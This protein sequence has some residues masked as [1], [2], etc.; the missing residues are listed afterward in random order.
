MI[1]RAITVAASTPAIALAGV[2]WLRVAQREHYLVDAVSRFALRWWTRVPLNAA[3]LVLAVAGLLLSSRWPAFAF[4]PIAVVA[5]GP[6]GL[7]LRGRTAPLAWT[8][9]LRTLALVWAVLEVAAVVGGTLAGEGPVAAA[10]GVLAVPALVDLACWVTSPFERRLARTHVARASARLRRVAPRVVAI[11]GSY[12]KTSTKGYVAHLLGGSRAVVASPA[13]FNNR[14]G[15][16]RAVNEHLAEGTEVFVAEMGTYGRGEIA[17]LCS[18]VRP[19]VAVITAVGPVHLERFGSEDNVVRAK[20]EILD[21][22]G[23][24]VLVV[25]DD[26][27]AAL[28]D[29]AEQAGTRVWRVS[30]C[31]VDTDV[32]V[33]DEEGGFTVRVHGADLAAPYPAT[34]G[35]GTSPRRWRWRSSSASTPATWRRAWRRCPGHRIAWS[36]RSA[37][38]GWSCS[39]TPTTPIRPAGAPRWPCWAGRPAREPDGWSSPRAWSSSGPA[40]SPR[41]PRSPR[42]PPRWRPT[43]SWWAAPTAAPCGAGPGSALSR[44]PRRVWWRYGRAPRRRSGSATISGTATSCCTR[45]TSPTT[46]LERRVAR[47]AVHRATPPTRG[48]QSLNVTTAKVAVVFGGPSP[49]HDVS[50][51]TGLQAARELAG[52]GR[53]VI[54]LYWTKTGAWV[55]VEPSL[56]ALDFVDGVPRGAQPVQLVTG[57]DT[58]GFVPSA[59]RLGRA[60]PLPVDVAVN[61]CH[62]GPGE[63]GSLQAA[64]D[65]AGVAYTGPGVAAAALGMDKLAFAGTVQAAGL[66]LLPR[67]L[68]HDDAVHGAVSADG[69]GPGGAGLGFPGPY[70]LK[71]RFGGSSIGVEVVADAETALARLDANVHLRAGAVVEPYRDDLFDLNVA[72]RTWPTVEVSAVERPL[73]S[74]AAAEILGYA[75]KYVGGEGMASAPRELPAQLDAAALRALHDAARTVVRLVALRGVARIDF[76]SD[77]TALFVNEVNTVPGSLARY[78]WV[79]PVLPFLELLDALVDEA[80]SRPA[81]QRSVA[82]ADGTV[83]RSAGGI[84]SKL[85]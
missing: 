20:A 31:R 9:R 2:R 1:L 24:A 71:P 82:G 68:L 5:V 25:D 38:G 58:P 36:A 21:G 55:R 40:R 30:A 19:D 57:G 29:T 49:E 47:R 74:T 18:W 56:E 27:L 35:P 65:L 75:D 70:I 44:A 50:I 6:V 39:T 11:T 84:A 32:C 14:A 67:A 52:A 12:G 80:L 54:G 22:V 7:S 79:D 8:R 48:A 26:R 73:R 34:A 43:W 63:D 61:C 78:L 45:T 3:A 62:G 13:S 33:L 85:A 46:T 69:R 53:D 64:L 10:A 72:V 17:E 60:R 76:L 51:L 42:R 77:G 59:G 41:T 4:A 37:P 16:A 15:L 28:A 83:L 81:V 23:C 66:P